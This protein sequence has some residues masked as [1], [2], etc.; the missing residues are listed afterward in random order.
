ME[1]FGSS[2][3][4]PRSSFLAPLGS[5]SKS[6]LHSSPLHFVLRLLGDG[7]A[8]KMIDLGI[9]GFFRAL[10]TFSCSFDSC[11]KSMVSDEAQ[12]NYSK[13]KNVWVGKGAESTK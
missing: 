8:H 6:I 9:A 13:S 1:R 5:V 3:M 10:P 2:I 11:I 7:K 4:G 12:A